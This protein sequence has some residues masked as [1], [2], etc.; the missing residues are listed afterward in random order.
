[1]GSPQQD[2]L[3]M[4]RRISKMLKVKKTIISGRPL[5]YVGLMCE[6]LLIQTPFAFENGSGIYFPKKEITSI[7]ERITKYNLD[8]LIDFKNQIQSNFKIGKYGEQGKTFSMTVFPNSREDYEPL[9]IELGNAVKN[10]PGV[11]DVLSGNSS[12]DIVIKGVNKFNALKK[13]LVQEQIAGD[14]TLVIGDGESDLSLINNVQYSGAP[15]NAIEAVKQS[16]TY[17]SK[18]SH[19]KGVVDILTFFNL[20]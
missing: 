7:D 9:R 14:K 11:F 2:T 17:C 12:F 6:L 8:L 18:F 16:A 19:I 13:I 20:L 10:Y 5:P 4:L 15:E 1:M 3:F